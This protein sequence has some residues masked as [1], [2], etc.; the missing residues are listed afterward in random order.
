MNLV[1]FGAPG[2]GKGTQSGFLI[3]RYGVPQISTGDI[4]RAQRRAGTALGERV[5]GYMDRG[6]LVPDDVMID[7][8]RDRLQQPDTARGFIL[9]GFPRTV[10]QAKALDALLEQLHKAIDAVLY[11]RVGRQ[12][13]IDRL[14]HRYSC[15]TC[16][17]VYTFTPEQA[18]NVGRCER[19]G[20]ELYQR[21]D[22]RPDVVARRI[23]VFL[24]NTA[25]LIDYYE[26]Q[27]KLHNVDGQLSV[28]AVRDEIAQRL[29]RLAGH[30]GSRPA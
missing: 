27:H 1:I 4:L 11:L 9:D 18:R 6:E 12:A 26:A 30:N 3:Q 19:D 8:V 20:G 21:T 2:A 24:K 13:L 10:P 25:P 15:R 17:A 22:D 23:D 28:D 14:S 5:K 16:D 7:I 29:S